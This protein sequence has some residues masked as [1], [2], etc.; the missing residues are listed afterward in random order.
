MSQ[1]FN[2][3]RCVPPPLP[4]PP[5]ALGAIEKHWI[6]LHPPCHPSSSPTRQL[7]SM[8]ALWLFPTFNS[9]QRSNIRDFE[10][11]KQKRYGW[12]DGPTDGR[13][14]GPIDRPSYRDAKTRLKMGYGRTNKPMDRWTGGP[15]FRDAMTHLKTV[16]ASF[17]FLHYHLRKEILFLSLSKTVFTVWV[18]LLLSF[19]ANKYYK[20]KRFM[21]HS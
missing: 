4:P 7:S 17:T 19:A 3:P 18:Q 8:R 16:F 13:T 1:H 14:N 21:Y 2:G 9:S 15:S 6:G 20:W 12:T 5:S 11:L 10:D